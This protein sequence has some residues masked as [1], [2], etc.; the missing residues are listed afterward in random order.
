MYVALVRVGEASGSLD[1][2]LKCWP[3]SAL[4]FP[5]Q[6]LKR[7]LGD[8]VRYPLLCWGPRVGCCCSS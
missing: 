3:T 7:R 6:A 5:P 4:F 2:V 8:A 1:Q